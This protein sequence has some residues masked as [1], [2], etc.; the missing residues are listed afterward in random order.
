MVETVFF[1]WIY[2]FFESFRAGLGESTGSR[3]TIRRYLHQD[4]KIF[5]AFCC[6]DFDDGFRAREYWIFREIIIR[7]ELKLLIIQ[8]KFAVIARV[9]TVKHWSASI[10]LDC[11]N[12]TQLNA[13]SKARS[14]AA[15]IRAECLHFISNI[16]E[17]VLPKLNDTFYGFNNRNQI[18]ESTVCSLMI[19][20]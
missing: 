18:E 5:A 11:A 1:L 10:G 13:L 3:V 2:Y 20:I 7:I 6:W 15:S 9:M 14:W 17:S 12:I 19:P 4:M 16:R 8:Q